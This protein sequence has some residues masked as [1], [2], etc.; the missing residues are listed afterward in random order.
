MLNNFR[1]Y[2]EVRDSELDMQ[3]VVNNGCYAS[4]FEHARHQWMRARGI[5]FSAYAQKQ[6]FFRLLSV[7]YTYKRPLYSADQFYIVCL[8][9]TKNP[10]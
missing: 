8:Y 9:P 5:D 1:V 3:G 2:F 7:T 4:Y 10:T 6:Q